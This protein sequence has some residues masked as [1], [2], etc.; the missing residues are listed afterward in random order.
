[1][2]MNSVEQKTAKRL[3]GIVN[4]TVKKSISVCA[5]GGTQTAIQR[6]G[7][8][9]SGAIEKLQMEH[10]KKLRQYAQQKRQK[11]NAIKIDAVKQCLQLMV[12][13]NAL[14]AAKLKDCFCRLTTFITT[15]RPC[16]KLSC[17]PVTVLAFICGYE[18]MDFRLGFKY[19]V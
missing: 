1:M 14:V 19:C 13:S 3:L 12:A 2:Q 8:P 4:V 9:V 6:G 10:R 17:I 11:P 16:V 18:K 5:I 7:S 15:A